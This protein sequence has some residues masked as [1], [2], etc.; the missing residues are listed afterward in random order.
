MFT[1]GKPLVPRRLADP[2]QVQAES[3]CL[4]GD[5]HTTAFGPGPA[6]CLFVSSRAENGFY[7]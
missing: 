7:T 6:C 2:W 3:G 4:F 5:P 1:V